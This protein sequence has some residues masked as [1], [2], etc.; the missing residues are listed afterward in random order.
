MTQQM[1]SAAA[2]RLEN[3]RQIDGKFGHQHHSEASGVALSPT[4]NRRLNR[5]LDV[6]Q[7]GD[8]VR[9]AHLDGHGEQPEL[10][11][12]FR[13]D[14]LATVPSDY[15][16][17]YRHDPVDIQQYLG[18]RQDVIEEAMGQYYGGE[19]KQLDAVGSSVTYEIV[20][21]LDEPITDDEAYEI[22][23]QEFEPHNDHADDDLNN[24]IA[25]A[26][27]AH[28]LKKLPNPETVDEQKQQQFADHAIR[29]LYDDAQM[30]YDDEGAH[31]EKVHLAVDDEMKLRA[32]LHS[33][34]A[35][36]AGDLEAWSNQSQRD[37]A[38]E[39]YLAAAGHAEDLE[40]TTSNLNTRVIG[41]R[42]ERSF[43][44]EMP[45][46]DTTHG[47]LEIEDDGVIHIHPQVFED[48]AARRDQRIAQE[49]AE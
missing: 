21:A 27:Q 35:D 30:T 23:D 11:V 17:L 13:R 29:A 14:M 39:A 31:D 5:R 26:L 33:V 18:D 47:R 1:S 37:P 10:S 25:Q 9:S 12:A 36:N 3:A 24:H 4:D 20:K 7:Y 48:F 16:A 45:K 49:A 40:S 28:D 43:V 8:R 22:I 38:S 2:Q 32:A 6:R 41:R 46:L 15:A 19:A 42:L 34:Y 44:A